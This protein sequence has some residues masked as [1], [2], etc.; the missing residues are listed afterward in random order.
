MNLPGVSPVYFF[1]FHKCASSL[2]SKHILKEVDGFQHVDF[3]Y[4]PGQFSI[5]GGIIDIFSYGN[6]WPYRIELFDE[7]GR[8]ELAE[9]INRGLKLLKRFDLTHLSGD[10]SSKLVA[11]ELKKPS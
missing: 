8:C 3:V 6:E 11:F 10:P 5:R 9:G 7:E 1:T 4:E 2:F